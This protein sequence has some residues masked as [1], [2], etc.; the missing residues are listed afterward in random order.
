[1]SFF[2]V[3]FV[4]LEKVP[5]TTAGRTSKVSG[6]HRVHSNSSSNHNSPARPRPRLPGRRISGLAL[7]AA[8]GT[9]LLQLIWHLVEEEVD[10]ELVEMPPMGIILEQED[11]GG[12]D[13][14]P[15]WKLSVATAEWVADEAHLSEYQLALAFRMRWINQRVNTHAGVSTMNLFVCIPK[16]PKRIEN[17][18]SELG[19]EMVK[20]NRFAALMDVGLLR[21]MLYLNILL[22]LSI[23]YD[24][25]MNFK[26]VTPFFLVSMDF[27]KTEVAFFLS[28]S[29]LTN[30][31]ARVIVPPI[32]DNLRIR[33]RLLLCL[34]IFDQL[35]EK[36][37]TDEI[38]RYRLS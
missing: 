15:N 20:P 22:R 27:N 10:I 6:F 8:V 35:P 30:I 34:R 7:N 37:S 9:T 21:D 19:L 14:L 25:E 24:V 33:K 2:R 11:D 5:P 31:A 38:S 36:E 1:M 29:T 23:F 16:T 26:M 28:V 13:S 18:K 32:G 4:C 12:N 3:V 17:F